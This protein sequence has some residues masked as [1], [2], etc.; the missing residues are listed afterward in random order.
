[1]LLFQ[2]SLVGSGYPAATRLSQYSE[3]PLLAD[4]CR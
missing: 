1:M 4:S 2:V 3:C